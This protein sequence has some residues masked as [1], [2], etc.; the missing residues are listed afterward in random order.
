MK[1]FKSKINKIMVNCKNKLILKTFWDNQS[2]KIARQKSNISW[3]KL[4]TRH[5][6]ADQKE[7]RNNKVSKMSINHQNQ[8]NQIVI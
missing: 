2:M 3:M 5:Q 6:Q 7:T 1:K 4:A 8:E